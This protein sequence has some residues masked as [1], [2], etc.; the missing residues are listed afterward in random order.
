MANRIKD[1]RAPVSYRMKTPLNPSVRGT[2]KQS[3]RERKGEHSP[4]MH[5]QEGHN[6]P[7]GHGRGGKTSRGAR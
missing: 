4:A 5:H 2:G 1:P 7:A 6:H 3:D